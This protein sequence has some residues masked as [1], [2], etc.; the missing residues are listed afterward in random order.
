LSFLQLVGVFAPALAIVIFFQ[1]EIGKLQCKLC[2][3]DIAFRLVLYNSKVL[4]CTN[5]CS[6]C[7]IDKYLVIDLFIHQFAGIE[8]DEQVPFF[9]DCPFGYE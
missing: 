2:F 9:D 5:K 8:F 7:V 3:G 6:F 1:V 4:G